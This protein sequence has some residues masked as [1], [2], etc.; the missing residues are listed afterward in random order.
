MIRTKTQMSQAE[1]LDELVRRLD[2]GM[3]KALFRDAQMHPQRYV[4]ELVQRYA[5][6]TGRQGLLGLIT[7]Y[8][9]RATGHQHGCI[10]A[11]CSRV[12]VAA[13]RYARMRGLL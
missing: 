7:R 5:S 6:Q 3:Q 10:C 13:K 1:T 2:Y 8:A 11:R 9:A 12:R 4:G